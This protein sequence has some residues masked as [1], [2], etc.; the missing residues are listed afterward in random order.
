MLFVRLMRRMTCCKPTRSNNSA[1][2]T[3]AAARVNQPPRTW[4]AEE[5]CAFKFCHSTSGRLVA[6]CYKRKVQVCV[7]VCL[8]LCVCLS[9]SGNKNSC[10]TVAG[11]P[12]RDC[13]G[14]QLGD[15]EEKATAPG[16]R[17]RIHTSQL[18]RSQ[19]VTLM[20]FPFPK[21]RRN[22]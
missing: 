17:A 6:L 8:C 9:D 5:V 11:A 21:R 15:A 10:V 1:H 20:N 22:L 13:D 4:Q 14:Q 18:V 12:P 16:M 7:C 2:L 3:L 19:P